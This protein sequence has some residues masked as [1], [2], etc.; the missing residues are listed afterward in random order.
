MGLILIILKSRGRRIIRLLR[1]F[2]PIRLSIRHFEHLGILVDELNDF[3]GL[4]WVEA[5][6]ANQLGLDIFGGRMIDRKS[7]QL[8]A[9]LLDLDHCLQLLHL[10]DIFWFESVLHLTE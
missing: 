3:I 7:I 1:T 10:F 2:C 6:C 9:G 4:L 5:L 8:A